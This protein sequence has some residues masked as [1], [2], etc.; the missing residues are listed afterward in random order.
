MGTDVHAIVQVKI[1]G[2][3]ETKEVPDMGRNYLLFAVLADVRNGYGFAG[4]PTHKPITPIGEP[5]GLPEDLTLIDGEYVE[6]FNRYMNFLQTKTWLGDHSHSWL[7]FH[8]IKNYDWEQTIDR[9]GYVDKE[10]AEKTPE[11]EQPESWCG[12]TSDDTA[13]FMEWKVPMKEGIH[14]DF[15]Y[16]IDA[17]EQHFDLNDVRLVF[18]FDS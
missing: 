16:M 3:W 2:K 13:V 6:G 10:I 5:R 17:Y 8:E 9:C 12:G 7:T 14:K 4:V 18:G 15:F 11:G 1:N